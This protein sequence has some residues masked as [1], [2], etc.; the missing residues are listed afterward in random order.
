MNHDGIGKGAIRVCQPIICSVPGKH[1]AFQIDIPG[2]H[3]G[4]SKHPPGAEVNA[5]SPVDLTNISPRRPIAWSSSVRFR[6]SIDNGES[7]ATAQ[8]SENYQTCPNNRCDSQKCHIRL[9]PWKGS[10]WCAN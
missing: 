2:S 1:P 10:Q 3:V 6:I 8:H 9:H 5:T 4:G 7:T